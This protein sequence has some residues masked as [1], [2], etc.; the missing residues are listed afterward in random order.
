MAEADIRERRRGRR[1]AMKALFMWDAQEGG[2]ADALVAA[3][4][5]ME[6][7][8]APPGKGKAAADADDAAEWSEPADGAAA[9]GTGA[10]RAF[11]ERLVSGTLEHREVIDSLLESV[12]T[13]WSL[14][15][16][17]AV[18]RAILRLGSYEVMYAE[19]PEPVAV[20]EA[21]ELAKQY[22]TA[23]SPRFV[24]GVLG[25]VAPKPEKPREGDRVPDPSPGAGTRA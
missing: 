4:M 25:A 12:A 8:P 24:N 1:W 9:A 2:D 5:R 15:R 23:D 10:A 22:S 3:A 20:S 14:R 17:A 19:T 21:V 13:S 6:A 11:A 18:D 7:P 16:M